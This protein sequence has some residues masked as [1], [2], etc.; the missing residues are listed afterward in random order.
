M[1]VKTSISLNEAMPKNDLGRPP[2]ACTHFLKLCE[3]SGVVGE[4]T[5][6]RPLYFLAKEGEEI[7]AV[8][9]AYLKT[10]SFGE[11]IFDWAWADLYQRSGIPYYPKLVSAIPFSPVNVE[12]IIGDQK[13]AEDLLQAFA[14]FLKMRSQLSSAHALFLRPQE[15]EA[16]E[17]NGFFKRQTLQY[18]LD[19]NYPD[20]DGFMSALKSRKRKQIRK[21]R[22]AIA[23]SEITI[24][25]KDSGFSE[26]LMDRIYE[27]YLTTIDKKW[28]QAY[29]NKD[30][31]QRLARDLPENLVIALAK[32]E[33]RIIAMALFLKSEDTLYGR[34]WGC[35]PEENLP[36]LHFELSFYQGM[37]YCAKRGLKLFEAGAQGEQKL[38]R[39]FTP[40]EILSAHKLNLP[41]A[42]EAI[43]KHI[44]EENQLHLNEIENLKRHLPYK[45]GRDGQID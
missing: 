32:K 18:H 4:G 17:A 41:Q 8:L 42:H 1:E 19:W 21:E 45:E 27:L 31:F 38:L 40:V 33:D 5:G 28:G 25:L 24:E 37:E 30:F 34:Y 26:E 2:F 29:L 7:K 35:D 6:W 43:K 16:L 12:K 13:Y 22:R 15:L 3:N 11:F 23:Q 14:Q 39:G 10:D 9:P 44:E 36:Y 20:F